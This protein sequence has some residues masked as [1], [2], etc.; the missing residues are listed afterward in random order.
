MRKTLIYLTI[1]LAAA[2]CKKEEVEQPSYDT[3]GSWYQ[4]N[5]H[6]TGFVLDSLTHDPVPGIIVGPMWAPG[7]QYDTSNADGFYHQLI[8]WSSSYSGW[9]LPDYFPLKTKADTTASHYYTPEYLQLNSLANH[10]TIVHN[11]YVVRY[12]QLSVHVTGGSAGEYLKLRDFRPGS[13]AGKLIALGSDV[14]TVITR[15]VLSNRTTQV[16]L[17]V[18][19]VSYSVTPHLSGYGT[20]GT[21]SVSYP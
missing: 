17:F 13:P 3:D 2:A 6:V 20:T 8:Y 16:E 12:S 15:P 1:L 19:G 5:A 14:D 10:D 9:S 7:Y 11:M 21:I 4:Y 18:D